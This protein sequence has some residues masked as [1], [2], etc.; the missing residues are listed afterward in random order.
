VNGDRFPAVM[1]AAAHG[2]VLLDNAAGTQL[3][4]TARERIQ[5]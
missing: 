2:R 4:D 3:P 1:A 5:R